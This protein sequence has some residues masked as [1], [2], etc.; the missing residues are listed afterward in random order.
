MKARMATKIVLEVASIAEKK[1]TW[2]ENAANL[3]KGDL[4]KENINETIKERIFSIEK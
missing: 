1:V 3:A 2:Q 4:F